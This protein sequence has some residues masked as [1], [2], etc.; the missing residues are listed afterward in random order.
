[1]PRSNFQLNTI[2]YQQNGDQWT[3]SEI[4]DQDEETS[5][6]SDFLHRK[7]QTDLVC[8]TSQVLPCSQRRRIR[9]C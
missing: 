8:K 2:N 4:L 1:M 7:I 9:V 3:K 6:S 5:D